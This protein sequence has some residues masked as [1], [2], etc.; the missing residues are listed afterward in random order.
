METN[1]LTLGLLK[2]TIITTTKLI[3]VSLV[4]TEANNSMRVASF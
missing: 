3:P 4:S 1:I 2:Y